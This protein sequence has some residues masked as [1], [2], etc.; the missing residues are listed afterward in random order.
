MLVL[1]CVVTPVYLWIRTYGEIDGKAAMTFA[2]A[3]PLT[4]TP[5]LSVIMLRTRL[6]VYRLA[7]EN[8]RIAHMDELTLSLIHI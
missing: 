7:E 4:I 3:L 2:I 8:F 5:T 6:K 1:L